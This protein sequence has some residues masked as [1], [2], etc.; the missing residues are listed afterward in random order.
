MRP[1]PELPLPAFRTVSGLTFVGA[2]GNPRG[3]RDSDY[4]AFMPRFGLAYELTPRAVVRTGYGIYFGLLG[5]EFS[6]VQQPAFN[7]RTNIV[8]SRDNGRTYVASIANPLPGGIDQP[9]GAAGGLET[10]LGRSPAFFSNDGRRPYTQRWS[11]NIQI[12]T[13]SRSVGRSAISA[14]EVPGFARPLSLVPRR[15]RT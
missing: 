15:A 12:G 1:L 13:S 11:Y 6:T 9:R 2:G 5:A 4:R 3:I 7:Q 8:A 14:R 10:F